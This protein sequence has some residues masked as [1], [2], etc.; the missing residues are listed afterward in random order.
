MSANM[1]ISTIVGCKMGCAYCPQKTH[2]SNYSGGEKRMSFDTF[3]TCI[4]KIPKDVDI[5]FAG[6]SEPFL[7][8][9]ALLMIALS[10]ERGHKV[11]LFTTCYGMKL[12]DIQV[13]KNWKFSHFCLHL[14]DADGLMNIKVTP[15]YLQVLKECLPLATNKMCI[16]TI[17]HE[18]E[19]ITGKVE[20]GSK[21]LYSRAGNIAPLKIEPKKGELYCSAT[22]PK[23]DHN[24]LLPNGEVVLCCMDYS[25]DHIIGNLLRD[26]YEGLFQSKEYLNVM[27][28]L[29]DESSKILCRTCEIAGHA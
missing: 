4:K 28:G 2:I 6:M 23:I 3:M 5:V 16:G 14:P 15:E 19:K 20:D 8:D 18:V 26:T 27:N 13:M 24:V 21:G 25:Q 10:F 11:S 1:E 22:G 17:H 9:D 12:S 29:K 7:N